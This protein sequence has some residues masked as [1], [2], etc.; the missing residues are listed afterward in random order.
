MA[1]HRTFSKHHLLGVM[2]VYRYSFTEPSKA[3]LMKCFCRNG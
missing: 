3:P 2:Y 1:V